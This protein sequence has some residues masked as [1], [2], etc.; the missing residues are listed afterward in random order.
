MSLTRYPS[1]NRLTAVAISTCVLACTSFAAAEKHEQD[2][3]QHGSHEHGAAR[4]TVATTEDGLEISLESPA[5]NVFGLEH[6]ANTE[7]E[8]DIIQC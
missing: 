8:H 4:L 6:K 7:K 1:V 3:E 5:A 2:M